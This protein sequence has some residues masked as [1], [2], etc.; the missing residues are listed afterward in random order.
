[1]IIQKDIDTSGVVPVYIEDGIFS[2]GTGG[3]GGNGADVGGQGG[4]GQ[5]PVI[6][7]PSKSTDT[8]ANFIVSPQF[9]NIFGGTGG[10][11]GNGANVG[12]QGGIG[13]GPVI[14]ITPQSTDT[15]ANF[16]VSRLFGNIFGGTGGPG[17]ANVGGQGGIGKGA[18]IS[19]PSQSAD[20][21]TIPDA[22]PYH[23]RVSF[24]VPLP[25]DTFLLTSKGHCL[26]N[27]TI[28]ASSEVINIAQVDI[29]M[30]Y[31]SGLARE[32]TKISIIENRIDHDRVE[33]GVNIFT[34]DTD[35]LCFEMVVT[36]PRSL[37]IGRLETDLPNFSHDLDNLE[38]LSFG[39]ISLSGTNGKI[40]TKTLAAERLKLSTSNAAVSAEVV[41]VGRAAE[42]HTTNAP[43]SGTY[44]ATDSVNL[45][46]ING[47]ICVHAS[48]DAGNST[49]T[50]ELIMRTS[51]GALSS[52][53]ELKTSSESGGSF[54]VKTN[55][56]NARL[57]MRVESVPVQSVLTLEATTTNSQASVFLPAEYQGHI[58]LQA[59]NSVPLVQPS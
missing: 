44:H 46:T 11:G 38:G 47:N 51:N 16:I 53:V 20:T 31:D 41:L 58:Q 49:E 23:D 24:P 18:V 17:G 33:R 14:S 28:T 29:T 6:S 8:S 21:Y 34:S 55:T 3:P 59:S 15:S 50:K 43:I 13:Q 7:I 5:G 10:P 57:E 27:L 37:Y 12:G 42:V 40:Q 45:E 48:L 52:S 2:G 19:I 1:M 4:V 22:L 9:G 30:H 35:R 32:R 54:R 25:T 36:L 56:S 39:E 26:G